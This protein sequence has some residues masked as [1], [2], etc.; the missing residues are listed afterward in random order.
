MSI[1]AEFLVDKWLI[2]QLCEGA[3]KNGL[4]TDMFINDVV[5]QNLRHGSDA[6]STLLASDEEFEIMT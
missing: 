2:K 6:F 4:V 3:N 1:V 5:E